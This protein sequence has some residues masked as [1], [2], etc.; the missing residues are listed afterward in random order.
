VGF[1]N[2]AGL[3]LGKITIDGDLGRILAGDDN[4]VTPAAKSLVVGSIGVQGLN[5]AAAGGNLIS[6]FLGRLSFA[7]GQR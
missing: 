4:S 3:D 6:K 5:Y 1:L 2:A 7:H